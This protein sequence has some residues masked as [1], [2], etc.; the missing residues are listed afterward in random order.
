M[1]VQSSVTSVDPSL[2]VARGVLVVMIVG[3]A[4]PESWTVEVTHWELALIA[5]ESAFMSVFACV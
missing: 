4:T 3:S 1:F 5:A 2:P